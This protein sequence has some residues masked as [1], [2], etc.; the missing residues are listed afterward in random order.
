MKE[1]EVRVRGVVA[2]QQAFLSEPKP[3]VSAEDG[4]QS[5]TVGSQNAGR[6]A[7][8]RELLHGEIVE[9]SIGSNGGSHTMTA[10]DDHL[11][12]LSIIDGLG[13]EKANTQRN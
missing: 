11:L 7:E 1:D 6:N 8:I 13:C 10:E 4:L 5:F 12:E 3:V 2:S 9:I